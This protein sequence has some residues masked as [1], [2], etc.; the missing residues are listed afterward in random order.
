MRID[1]GDGERT[2]GVSEFYTALV[3]ALYSRQDWPFLAEGLQS[4]AK[5]DDGSTLLLLNDFYAGRQDDGTYSNFQQVLGVIVCDDDAEPLVSFDDFRATYDQLSA[6][7]PF[8]GPL[9]GSGPAGCDPRLPQ[10]HADEQVGDVRVADAP[11]VLVIG[12]TRD[13][14]T[15]YVGAKDLHDR[16][17]GSRLLTVDN[18]GH[19]SYATGN[20]CVDRIVNRYLVSGKAPARDPR[21][22]ARCGVVGDATREHAHLDAA[23]VADPL[24]RDPPHREPR[25][26]PEDLADLGGCEHGPGTSDLGEP[27]REVDH[28][29]EVV[30]LPE[31]ECAC[32]DAGAGQR[33]QIVTRGALR[34]RDRDAGRRRRSVGDE[35]HL[36]T[37]RLHDAPAARDDRVVCERAEAL[38][39]R[40]ELLVLELFGERGVADQVDE[41]DP[42]LD[43]TG[44][45][46]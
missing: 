11:P 42:A 14:A 21:C 9:F 8:F 25:I 15:P 41:P 20:R 43:D 32:R 2:V 40:D 10:P 13:P 31:H 37:D 35:H 18:T 45:T 6:E 17:D 16:I 23:D 5:H 34:E 30:T 28:R 12:N 26:P 44:S 3:A 29:T 1:G 19:G 27:R 33:Q 4:A 24:R 22:S 39:Q 46:R 36:V 7:F 38:Q